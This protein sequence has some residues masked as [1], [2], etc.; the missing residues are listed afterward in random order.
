M[1]F[2]IFLYE[3]LEEL[4]KYIN[5]IVNDKKIDRRFIFCLEYSEESKK[6]QKMK[7]IELIATLMT[8]VIFFV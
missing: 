2:I 5:I 6:Q 4:E 1:P 3:D 7:Y 8:F